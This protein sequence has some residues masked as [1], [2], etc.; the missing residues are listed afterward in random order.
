[1]AHGHDGFLCTCPAG[2]H[3]YHLVDDGTDP[4][5]LLASLPEELHM[6]TTRALAAESVTLELRAVL[7]GML[8]EARR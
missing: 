1:L 2:E 7:V 6:G 4:E 5:A 8:R 3:A